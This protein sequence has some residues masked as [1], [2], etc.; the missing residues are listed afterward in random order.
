MFLLI[1]TRL[2]TKWPRGKTH[3]PLWKWLHHLQG[4]RSSWQRAVPLPL[5]TTEDV[6]RRWHPEP[7]P[8]LWRSR[9]GAGKKRL[10]NMFIRIGVLCLI[11][12]FFPS[13]MEILQTDIPFFFFFPR[14]LQFSRCSGFG[15]FFFFSLFPILGNHFLFK[16]VLFES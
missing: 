10:R 4:K 5:W 3:C 15:L 16:R 1:F 2:H 8:G 12:C 11:Y 7:V 6:C 14:K 9:G 13:W